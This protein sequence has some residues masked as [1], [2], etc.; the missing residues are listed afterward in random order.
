MA[1]KFCSLPCIAEG[2]LVCF[3]A[4]NQCLVLG[5][6]CMSFN[7]FVLLPVVGCC[8]FLLCFF[9]SMFLL[10]TGAWHGLDTG[11]LN[12]PLYLKRYR[13]EGV[14]VVVGGGGVVLSDYM[15]WLRSCLLQSLPP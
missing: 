13:Q 12:G 4:A 15:L 2:F 1:Y 8:W 6:K 3:Y 9:V 11:F 7:S 14:V 10:L 5:F